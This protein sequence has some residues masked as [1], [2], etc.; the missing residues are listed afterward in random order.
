MDSTAIYE[1]ELIE[2]P[3]RRETILENIERQKEFLLINI[4]GQK[5][6]DDV[7][8]NPWS[9]V[10]QWHNF[11]DCVTNIYFRSWDD[12]F[13]IISSA[14]SFILLRSCMTPGATANPLA[15]PT[16]KFICSTMK[17]TKVVRLIKGLSKRIISPDF[18]KKV[19]QDFPI[20]NETQS[21]MYNASAQVLHML[22]DTVSKYATHPSLVSAH[23]CGGWI[24]CRFNARY[25]EMKTL[26]LACA[27]Y[28]LQLEPL[29][30]GICRSC[31]QKNNNLRVWSL[32]VLTKALASGKKLGGDD[33]WNS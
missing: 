12:N 16:D 10:Q 30:M 23:C 5:W 21:Y 3:Q 20:R 27:F 14:F 26:K 29:E 11:R 19:T 32:W 33:N 18:F 22:N 15:P 1:D 7:C 25:K 2:E 17:E 28:E 6:Y 9:Q 13:I 31:K 4:L 24:Y 8:W